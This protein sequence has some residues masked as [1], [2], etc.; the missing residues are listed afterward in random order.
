M[1]VFLAVGI[2]S[3]IVLAVGLLMMKARA[4]LLPGA[5][6]RALLS[7]IA[8]WVRD[9][10]WSAGLGVQA[11]G[12]AL[13]IGALAHVPVSVMAVVMQG[14]IGVFVLLAVMFLGERANAVEWVGLAGMLVAMIMLG[15]SLG[16]A[17]PS[18]PAGAATIATFS[19]VSMAI[20]FGPMAVR[21]L[22]AN[23]VGLALASGI[24]SGLGSLY[25]KAITDD[26]LGSSLRAIAYAVVGD[27]YVYLTMITNIAGLILLQNAFHRA[28]GL[29]AMPL[30]SALSNIIP[31]AG[32]MVA[33]GERLPAV[34]TLAVLR[35]GAFGLTIVAGL[36][37]STDR[38]LQP[39]Q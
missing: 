7:A 2:L 6:G 3:S 23:G 8:L 27:P 26:L 36:L 10:V 39:Q 30:S 24:C 29:I 4:H 20:A 33:F 38:A 16:K 35:M 1:A 13:Y 17:E 14:G 12:Y 34:P 15:L 28:R 32:G 11:I 22:R 18:H 37:L 21:P 25:P 31:I 19:I 5:H 9:P